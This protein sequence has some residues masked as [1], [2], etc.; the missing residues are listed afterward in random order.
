MDA[1]QLAMMN[2]ADPSTMADLM[3][4]QNALQQKQALAQQLMSQQYI[5]NSGKAGVLGAVLSHLVGSMQQGRNN[6]SMAD[7]FKQQF[8][9]QNQAAQAKRAQDL[10]DEQRKMYE[11]IFE[12]GSIDTNKSKAERDYQKRDVSNGF[13]VDPTDP[14]KSMAIPGYAEQQIG[15]KAGEA[16]AT[17]AA[18]ARYR[19]AP[20]AGESA[21]LRNKIALAMQ[22][23]ASQ[24]DIAR[25]LTG[26]DSSN[27]I[28]PGVGVVDKDTGQ[29]KPMVGPDGKPVQ[30]PLTEA[31]QAL[32]G[33]GAAAKQALSI[34][35]DLQGKLKAGKTW[36][37]P[38]DQYIPGE[39]Q[40]SFQAGVDQLV[41]PLQT[42]TRVPGQGSQSDT[43][44]RQLMAGFPSLGSREDVNQEKIARLRQY[45]ANL[46]QGGQPL[47][48]PQAPA[49][50]QISD[51]DLLK[52]Y[53]GL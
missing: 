23:G 2:F 17:A 20:G 41:N 36:T 47:G 5:P 38:I 52:K 9:A 16:N 45:I 21:A 26:H 40:Q 8:Q 24:S 49:P 14:T 39:G 4:Q 32:A 22:M 25:M 10:Q 29:V 35:D 33:K 13:I 44:L 28:V 31:Q 34:L 42:L 43:E 46:T 50:G 15:I 51:A 6:E 7:I 19:E 48:Q 18:N 1:T 37:G 12:Q 11:K 3:A 30:Q 53:G 27:Q